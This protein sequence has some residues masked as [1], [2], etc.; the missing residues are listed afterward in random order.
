M[1]AGTSG[2]ARVPGYLGRNLP[3]PY[4]LSGS[5][6][7]D[8]AKKAGVC[9]VK[10]V[11]MRFLLPTFALFMA[12]IFAQNTSIAQTKDDLA[13]RELEAKRAKAEWD[14]AILRQNG[15][16]PPQAPGKADAEVER[17]VS[18]L[19]V[20]RAANDPTAPP[21]AGP[22]VFQGPYSNNFFTQ[23]SGRVTTLA[24]DPRDS[25]WCTPD[26]N[27]GGLWKTTDAAKHEKY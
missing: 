19:A 14:D 15:Y 10:G 9:G 21:D 13:H 24:V 16:P 8:Q 12:P 11:L 27:H 26:P 3:A 7:Y 22:W 1:N 23:S 4:S 2:L 25:K 20:R 17:L 18:E 6:A 5:T